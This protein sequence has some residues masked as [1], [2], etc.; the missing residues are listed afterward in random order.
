MKKL[1]TILAAV[2]LIAALLAGC[3][4]TSAVAEENYVALDMGEAGVQFIV[5]GNDKVIALSAS[6]QEGEECAL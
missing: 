3:Q 5:D 2:T 6:T 4:T 1:L